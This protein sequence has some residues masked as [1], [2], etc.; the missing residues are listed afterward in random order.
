MPERRNSKYPHKS[1]LKAKPAPWRAVGTAITAPTLTM[2]GWLAMALPSMA[3]YES[4]GNPQDYRI[5]ASQLLKAGIATESA[6]EAC[7]NALRPRDLSSCVVRIERQTQI[8]AV[9]ALSRCRQARRPEDLRRCVVSISQNTK[10]TVNPAVLDYCGRSL[11]PVRF[12]QCVVGLRLATN[13]DPSQ[14]LDTCID[15]SD[16]GITGFL[17]SFIPANTTNTPFQPSFETTPTPVEPNTIPPANPNT[18]P[19]EPNTIPPTNPNTTPVEPSTIPPE[20]L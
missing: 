18:T 1:M 2:L 19:V 12:A 17:P 4:Y 14:A 10:E 3:S 5:C 15:G 7:A 16:F 13:L 9:D 11:L 8:A 6:T 20:N